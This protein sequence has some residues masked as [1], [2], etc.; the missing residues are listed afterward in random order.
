MNDKTLKHFKHFKHGDQVYCP[1]L[2]RQVYVLKADDSTLFVNGLDCS[3]NESGFTEGSNAKMIFHLEDRELLERL[4]DDQ[5]D[6][7]I[8][9]CD[10]LKVILAHEKYVACIDNRTNARL[11]CSQ[12]DKNRRSNGHMRPFD[13]STGRYIVDIEYLNVFSDIRFVLGDEIS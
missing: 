8:D 9:Y 2:G 6:M 7:E 4:Y 12:L 1:T 13:L 10:L 5:F 3:I 11:I